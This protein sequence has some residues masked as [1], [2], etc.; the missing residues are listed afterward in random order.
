MNLYDIPDATGT[1]ADAD[2]GV[3]VR[4]GVADVVGVIEAG[5]DGWTPATWDGKP[6]SGG[7]IP[8]AASASACEYGFSRNSLRRILW[9]LVRVCSPNVCASMK[10]RAHSTQ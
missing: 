8:A 4:V 1:S 7:P 6:L 3:G 10:Y 5:G 2:V 9:R